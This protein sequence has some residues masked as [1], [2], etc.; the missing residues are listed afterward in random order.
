MAVP[1]TLVQALLWIALIVGFFGWLVVTDLTNGKKSTLIGEIFLDKYPQ[2]EY[3]PTRTAIYAE[4]TY[5]TCLTCG[6]L[7]VLRDP[8]PW[9]QPKLYRVKHYKEYFAA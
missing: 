3:D 2:L 1:M 5:H 4:N 8:R 9:K 7:F 6:T